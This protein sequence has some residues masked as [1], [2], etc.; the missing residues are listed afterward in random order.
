MGGIKSLWDLDKKETDL[1][2]NWEIATV[3]SCSMRMN[4][5]CYF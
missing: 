5:W 2:W 4:E 1:F 3:W